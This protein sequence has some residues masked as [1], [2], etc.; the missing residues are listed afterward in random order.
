[1][2]LNWRKIVLTALIG[3]ALAGCASNTKTE[4]AAPTADPDARAFAGTIISLRPMRSTMLISKDEYHGKDAFPNE[5]IVKYDAQTKFL[6]D[7]QPTTIDR[8]GQY[9][10]VNVKGHMRDG[11]MVAEVANFSS[12]LPKNVKPTAAAPPPAN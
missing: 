2:R 1:M 3:A 9:M 12:V 10:N 11:E 7:G 5:I 6:M 8:I 4:T